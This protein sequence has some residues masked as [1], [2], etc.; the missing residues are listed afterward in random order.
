MPGERAEGITRARIPETDSVVP[1]PTDHRR[2]IRTKRYAADRRPMPGERAEGIT[3]ARIPETDDEVPSCDG[4]AIWTQRD[5]ADPNPLM[6]GERV[7]RATR[8]SHPRDGRCCPN[9][10]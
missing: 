4:G 6:P 1:T 10:R 8:G 7:E 5:A 3:R 9:S 2:S